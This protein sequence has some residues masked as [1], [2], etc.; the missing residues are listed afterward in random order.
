LLCIVSTVKVIVYSP[1]F[2]IYDLN[3]FIGTRKKSKM[4]ANSVCLYLIDKIRVSIINTPELEDRVKSVRQM[5][6]VN[7]QNFVAIKEDL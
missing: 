4:L 3:G 2:L 6:Q 1:P 5:P 7:L